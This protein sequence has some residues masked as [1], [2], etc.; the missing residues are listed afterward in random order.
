MEFQRLLNIAR[1]LRESPEPE[2]FTMKRYFNQ[3]GTP[4]CALGHY[5]ARTDLQ[6]DFYHGR[7]GT[8]RHRVY[9]IVWY[10]DPDIQAHFGIN[11]E[12]CMELFASPGDETD[13]E[14]ADGNLLV[15]DGGCGRART[16]IEAAEYIEAFVARK[17]AEYS[18]ETP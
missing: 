8:I 7:D 11:R 1:A 15:H 17:R 6:S 14:D 12:E 13:E 9:G 2:D 4:A 16:A 10:D 5:V 18:G 3:C